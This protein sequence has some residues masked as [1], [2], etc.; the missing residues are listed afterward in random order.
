MLYPLS[1]FKQFDDAVVG[2]HVLLHE[3]MPLTYMEP[4]KNLAGL[5]RRF[6][7]IP[8]IS[9]V[10]RRATR[11]YEEFQH[12]REYMRR[13]FVSVYRNPTALGSWYDPETFGKLVGAVSLWLVL[14]APE[15][16]GDFWRQ[17]AFLA[18]RD[19]AKQYIFTVACSAKISY[20]VI[21]QETIADEATIAKALR[22]ADQSTQTGVFAIRSGPRA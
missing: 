21:N 17:Q 8:Q 1:R 7:T 20:I 15:K 11:D 16:R 3:C 19:G 6:D 5:S 18:L 10:L 13:T 2:V 22:Q 4:A 9:D 14:H 12:A